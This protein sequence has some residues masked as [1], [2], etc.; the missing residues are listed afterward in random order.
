VAA[1]WIE[2][3]KVL[4]SRGSAF[5]GFELRPASHLDE[6]RLFALHREAMQDYVAATWGWDEA[7][8]R[9][10][11]QSRAASLRAARFCRHR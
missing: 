1:S 7:W 9:A 5:R 8:Q 3:L 2:P 11:M 4:L 10:Q 6:E